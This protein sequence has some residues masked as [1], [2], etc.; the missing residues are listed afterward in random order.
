MFQFLNRETKKVYTLNEIDELVCN[1]WGVEIHPRNYAQPKTYGP[2]WFDVIGKAVEDCQYFK[3]KSFKV[4]DYDDK[5]FDMD[6]ISSMVIFHLSQYEKTADA[7][8]EQIALLKP[9]IELCY[10]LKSL[11]IVGSGHG[12]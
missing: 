12:W 8:M 3:Y 6:T 4:T 1:F 2:N 9:Y 11:N 5:C 10:H 7:K